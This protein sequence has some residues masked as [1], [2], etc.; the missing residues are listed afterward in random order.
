M[1]LDWA[2]EGSG[3]H[4]PSRVSARD[5]EDG[6][7][8]DDPDAVGRLDHCSFGHPSRLPVNIVR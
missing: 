7:N 2:Q 5:V 3:K 8:R 6:Y 1:L 4:P